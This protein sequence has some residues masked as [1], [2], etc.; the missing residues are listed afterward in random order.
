MYHGVLEYEVRMVLG[1]CLRF[2]IKAISGNNLFGCCILGW[3][4]A[5]LLFLLF[6]IHFKKVCLL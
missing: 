3:K 5:I 4:L 6:L 2:T 1:Y